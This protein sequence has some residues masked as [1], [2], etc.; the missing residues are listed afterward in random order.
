MKTSASAVAVAVLWTL[1]ATP[2]HAT[3]AR[4]AALAGHPFMPDDTDVL[5]F[6]STALRSAGLLTVS[7][8]DDVGPLGEVGALLG[9]TFVAGVFL[10]SSAGAGDLARRAEVYPGAG[11]VAPARMADVVVAW[12]PYPGQTIGLTAGMSHSLTRNSNADAGDNGVLA[13][14]FGLAIGHSYDGPLGSVADT[15]IGLDFSYFRRT[16]RFEVTHEAPIVAAFDLR[17]RSLWTVAPRWQ[18]GGSFRLR[19]DDLGLEMPAAARTA[20]GQ[21]WNIDVEVGPRLQPSERV[22]LALSARFASSWW[23][24]TGFDAPPQIGDQGGESVTTL[25]GFRAAAEAR[26]TDWA[27]A[28]MG[29]VGGHVA[30][31]S[32]DGDGNEAAVMARQLSWTTGLGLQWENLHI[33]GRLQAALLREGPDAVGGQAPGLFTTVSVSYAF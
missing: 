23:E 30:V 7:H 28:R 18:L 12:T 33:D 19:R 3:P 20:S 8:G 9:E 4:A 5:P 26:L 31:R 32:D 11:I 29:F 22:T 24:V 13:A 25:P 16:Q 14:S 21:A 27:L 10:G 17:H 15:S 2:A 6:P 1:A